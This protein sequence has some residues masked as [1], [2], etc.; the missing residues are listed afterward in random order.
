MG[1]SPRASLRPTM[2]AGDFGDAINQA[3]PRPPIDV[4]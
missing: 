3:T 2:G 4:G 1:R